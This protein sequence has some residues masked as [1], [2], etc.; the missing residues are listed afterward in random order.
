L[1]LKWDHRPLAAAVSPDDK[2]LLFV[3]G[4]S[5]GIEPGWL[6]AVEIATGKPLA[7]FPRKSSRLL[8]CVAF[9]R[10]GKRVCWGD[11]DGSSHVVAASNWREEHV[12]A[13]GSPPEE[14]NYVG[15]VAFSPDGAVVASG[16]A[17][18]RIRL[19]DA[20][21]GRD[22]TPTKPVKALMPPEP[23]PEEKERRAK[24]QLKIEIRMGP[25]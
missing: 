14:P 2:T 16:H 12:L 22:V 20:A 7:G 4:D 21:S 11:C 23:S 19:W 5:G 15:C 24:T 6:N 10:D 1:D 13:T 3:G 9:S 25:K 17:D 8:T 18:G